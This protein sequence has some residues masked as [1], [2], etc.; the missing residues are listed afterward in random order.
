MGV[1]ALTVP[2][3][4]P[5]TIETLAQLASEFKTDLAACKV[6]LYA[7]S[8]I[9]IN[10]QTQ[11][12]ELTFAEA[13]YDGYTAGGVAVANAGSP[14]LESDGASYM[15]S[16]PSVQ[17][18]YSTVTHAVANSILGAFVTD[19]NGVLRGV[20]PFPAAVEMSQAGDAV[21]VLLTWRFGPAPTT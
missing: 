11:L 21:V 10:E 12:A 1:Q 9:L 6:R 18:N 3:V 20:F 5:L 19:A 14:Y 17:F 7:G 13:T 4:T 15:V 16:L 2:D 8:P